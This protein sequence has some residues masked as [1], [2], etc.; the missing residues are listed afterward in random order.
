MQFPVD[1]CSLVKVRR[2]GSTEVPLFVIAE[3]G[4]VVGNPDVAVYVRGVVL[5]GDVRKRRLPPP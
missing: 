5:A 3:R 2:K 4:F 1:L